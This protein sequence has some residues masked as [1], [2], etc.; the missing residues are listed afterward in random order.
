MFLIIHAI[1]K[2]NKFMKRLFMLLQKTGNFSEW[3]LIKIMKFT[4]ERPLQRVCEYVQS[5]QRGKKDDKGRPSCPY[6]F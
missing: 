6:K 3:H 2:T 4:L 5:R 1:A